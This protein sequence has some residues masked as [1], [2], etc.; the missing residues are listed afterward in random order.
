VAAVLHEPASLEDAGTRS[1][2]LAAVGLAAERDRLRAEVG[3]QVDAVEA[4]R[5]RL[6]AAEEEERRRLAARL[7]DG[8]GA[9]LA[10]VERLVRDAGA[11]P[12]GDGELAAALARASAGLARVRPELDALVRGLGGVGA[13]GLVPAFERLAA[14][15]P[16]TLDV[17]DVRVSPEAASALWFVCSESI[18][19][20][21][22]HAEAASITVTL[23]QVGG[24]VRLTVRDDGRGGADPAGPG[25]VGLADRLAALGGRLSVVSPPE[26]GTQ[27][28]AELPAA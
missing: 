9:A 11:T 3:R 8:P 27:V 23:G 22:K 12:A 18:A 20:A 19:N 25:L 7:D 17:D 21:V 10:A 6:L 4:S 14:G 24:V 15:L 5:R 2:V 26:G 13:D 16:V 1:A 28:V